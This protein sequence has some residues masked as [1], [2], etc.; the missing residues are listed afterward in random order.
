MRDLREIA[1][2]G[3]SP[4]LLAETLI[5]LI[6]LTEEIGFVRSQIAERK[7]DIWSSIP[8]QSLTAKDRA[9]TYS[10]TD[11]TMELERLEAAAECLRIERAFIERLL[12]DPSSAH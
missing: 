11:L 3:A 7:R 2:S 9:A 10:S 6:S 1:R 4:L 5:E 12:D 8:E